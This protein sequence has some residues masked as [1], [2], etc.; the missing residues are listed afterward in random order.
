M[1]P[2][3]W[4]SRQEGT[5]NTSLPATQ[6]HHSQAPQGEQADQHEVNQED[7]DRRFS[8]PLETL[9]GMQQAQVELAESLRVLR[10]T[11]GPTPQP[12]HKG[13]DPRTQQERGSAAGNPQSGKQN[14]F[15]S[16]FATL[17]DFT[18][19]VRKGKA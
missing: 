11:Q 1:P 12:L 6:S 16:Q 4:N 15:P 9:Q 17:S 2:R 19:F 14:A 10:E 5:R 18:A 8:F 7:S 3:M 13:P